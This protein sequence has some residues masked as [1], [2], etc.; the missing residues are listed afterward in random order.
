M[1]VTRTSWPEC[2]YAWYDAFGND[3]PV[4]TAYVECDRA[5]ARVLGHMRELGVRFEDI[6][7]D[8]VLL[9]EAAE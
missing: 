3:I 6:F 1:P 9:L 8:D 7:I 4:P 5:S 2:P